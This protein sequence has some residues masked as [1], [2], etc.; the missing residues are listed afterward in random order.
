MAVYAI[1]Q[2][3]PL[4]QLAAM[5]HVVCVQY[6]ETYM[7]C[8]GEEIIDSCRENFLFR[9]PILEFENEYEIYCGYLQKCRFEDVK[10]KYDVVIAQF[11]EGTELCKKERK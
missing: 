3:E 7:H 10:E 2:T 8:H 11:R 6:D 1:Y 5:Y 4:P 9:E